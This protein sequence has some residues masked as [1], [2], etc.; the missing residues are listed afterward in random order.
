MTRW[1]QFL[2]ESVCERSQ[3]RSLGPLACGLSVPSFEDFSNFY[4]LC[5]FL[6]DI[7]V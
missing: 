1:Y 2:N 7:I 6:Q 5:V 4:V 3:E